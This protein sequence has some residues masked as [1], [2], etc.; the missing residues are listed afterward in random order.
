MNSV[1][2][3]M[4]Q[5]PEREPRRWVRRL[6]WMTAGSV[7]VLYH[8]IGMVLKPAR[9][10]NPRIVQDEQR[11]GWQVGQKVPEVRMLARSIRTIH[12]Q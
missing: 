4:E 6:G 10:E 2:R 1:I 5:I 8:G 7:S 12:D 9:R 11:P 3:E